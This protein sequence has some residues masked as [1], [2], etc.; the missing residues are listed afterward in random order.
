MRKSTTSPPQSSQGDNM[1]GI[2]FYYS[3][4]GNTKLACEYVCRHLP[5]VDFT[6]RSI[7][8]AS[9]S[10]LSPYEI[11]GFATWADFLSAS[12]LFLR[13]IKSLP[14]QNG[15]NAFLI[16]TYGMFYGRTLKRMYDAVIK[17]GFSVIAA[18]ALHTPENIA[19]MICS[20]K[21]NVQA[22]DEKELAS[23]K[24]FIE[25]VKNGTIDKKKNG[26]YVLPFSEN[27]LPALPRFIGKLDMG[28]KMVDTARC[29]H[30]GFCVTVCPVNAISLHNSPLFDETKCNACW[31]CFNRCPQK[32]IYTKKFRDRG[33]YPGPLPELIEKLSK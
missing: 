10:D 14:R 7:V 30:C 20:G 8:N 16:C 4:T 28:K 2:I 17:R 32:A 22:P 1:K 18:S 3:N 5:A 19:A 31:A 27:F 26:K 13:F 24:K 11:V 33:H 21:A 15:K 12:P 23:F 25:A 29:T 9:V 6:L